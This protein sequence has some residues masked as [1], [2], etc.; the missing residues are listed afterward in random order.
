MCC[1]CSDTICRRWGS[2]VMGG[3]FLLTI[4]LAL[5]APLAS[6]TVSLANAQ[7][8]KPDLSV[9]QAEIARFVRS[10]EGYIDKEL[11]D[12]FWALMPTEMKLPANRKLIRDFLTEVSFER[13][14]FMTEAW[15]S[16]KASLAAK[17][18]VKTDGYIAAQKAAFTVSNTSGYQSKIRES[19]ESGERLIAAAA[20]G[21]PLDTPGGK[22]FIT[23]DLVERVL[24][25]ITASEFRIAKLVSPS[26]D[27]Q[28]IEFRYPE[29]HVS[30]LATSPFVIERTKV[31]NSEGREVE[32]VMLNQRLDKS[33]HRMIG[34][35]EVGG[36][37]LDP[38]KSVIS[39]AKAGISGAGATA[40]TH[41]AS[42]NWRGR[43]SA[44]VMGSAK[45]SEGEF[46][47]AV[48]VVAAPELK[49]VVQFMVVS[50]LSGAEAIS[51]RGTLEDS[52][53]IVSN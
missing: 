21:T 25:G 36:D 8:L 10:V 44:T 48:R 46:F 18:L 43:T 31:K 49:G 34:F 52:S 39:I 41:T 28:V 24:S 42:L 32:M 51:M 3:R 27:E 35:T 2:R 11:Y 16:A 15:L 20:N 53:N 4:A 19:V 5:S 14:K 45:T 38:S 6:I 37:F 47:V 22:T 12:E 50:D 40:M 23:I 17:R 9:R 13:E 1:G 33:S 29:A 7:V 26:W 30:V